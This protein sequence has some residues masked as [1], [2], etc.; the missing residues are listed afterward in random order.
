MTECQ[1]HELQ[2]SALLDGEADLHE[3]VAVIDH[4]LACTSCRAFYTQARELQDIVDELPSDLLTAEASGGEAAT[5]RPAGAEGGLPRTDQ[6]RSR[7]LQIPRWGLAAAA[8]ILLSLGFWSGTTLRGSEEPELFVLP[9]PG[10]PIDV[11]LASN[12]GEMNEAEFMNLA[13]D[14]LHADR[15]Y[16]RKMY[17]IL[18]LLEADGPV[19]SEG[20]VMTVGNQLEG[21][22]DAERGIELERGGEAEPPGSAIY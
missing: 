4:L 11:R 3:Q 10:E 9:T 21:N 6:R 8:L 12:E 15:R 13:L 20:E 5:G 22:I 16:H 2:I 19:S 1:I 7:V 18:Q 17:Q 14:L